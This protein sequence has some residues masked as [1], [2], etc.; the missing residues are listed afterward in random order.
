[1]IRQ[2]MTDFTVILPDGARLAARETGAG[3]A[4]LLV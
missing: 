4:V 3:E 2:R 1:M